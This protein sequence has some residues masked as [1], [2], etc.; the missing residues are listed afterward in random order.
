MY[1]TF[2]L[3]LLTLENLLNELN[4]NY[5]LVLFGFVL[6]CFYYVAPADLKILLPQPPKEFFFFLNYPENCELLQWAKLKKQI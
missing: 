5:T 6:F 1:S 2:Y 3:V 4:L